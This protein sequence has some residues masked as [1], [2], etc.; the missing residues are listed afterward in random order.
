MTDVPGFMRRRRNGP[1]LLPAAIGVDE[2]AMLQAMT[3]N[4]DPVSPYIPK[5]RSL[6]TE[7]TAAIKAHFDHIDKEADRAASALENM[8]A[9]I[10]YRAK[11]DKERLLADALD[12]EA[13]IND[14]LAMG[15][16]FRDAYNGL[17]ERAAEIGRERQRQE[18]L[19][20]VGGAPE[21]PAQ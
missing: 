19:P 16:D 4:G 2:A 11:E 7:Y 14:G 6:S 15:R 12:T 18:D 20:A 3:G 8:A 13:R 17:L 21:E 1:E 9:D 5:P 10:R